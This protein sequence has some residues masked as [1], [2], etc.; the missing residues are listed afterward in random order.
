MMRMFPAPS[1]RLASTKSFSRSEIVFP[2]TTRDI[3]PREQH[4]HRNH[5]R[6]TRL[7]RAAETPFLGGR[8]R[9]DDPDRDES[10]GTA[11][12][13]SAKRDRNVSA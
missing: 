11:S 2:R 4:D 10:T 1:E 5:D 8:A 3:W 9:R 6:E 13:T 7:D 12:I